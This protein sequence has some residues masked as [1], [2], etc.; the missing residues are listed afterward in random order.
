M[1]VTNKDLLLEIELLSENTS[2]AFNDYC[3]STIRLVVKAFGGKQ[4]DK[5]YYSSRIEL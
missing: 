4:L 3:N 1:K 5:H 2:I